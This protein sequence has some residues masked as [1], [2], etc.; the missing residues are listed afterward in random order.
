MGIDVDKK[1][2]CLNRKYIFN[3][4]SDILI[5]NTKKIHDHEKYNFDLT[6]GKVKISINKKN[7]LSRCY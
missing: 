5:N 2:I 1:E 4:L 6:L 3:E 7:N